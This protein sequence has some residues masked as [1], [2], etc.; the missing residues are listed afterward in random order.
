MD[1][2]GFLA[3][4][5]CA[6]MAQGQEGRIQCILILTLGIRSFLIEG[7]GI[8]APVFF[9]QTRNDDPLFV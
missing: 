6:G 9:L 8:K 1:H 7:S 3:C 4:R 2:V 5:Q